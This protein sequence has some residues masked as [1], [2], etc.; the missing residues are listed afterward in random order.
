[1][2]R[3]KKLFDTGPVASAGNGWYVLN[4]QSTLPIAVFG[5]D[6]G[7]AEKL[8]RGLEKGYALQRDAE[9]AIFGM[10]S[11]STTFRCR[12]ID[13]YKREFS[14]PFMAAW[15][16]MREA[17]ADWREL[18]AKG[19]AAKQRRARLSAD[20]HRSLV[21]AWGEAFRHAAAVVSEDRHDR[22]SAIVA[23]LA[24][25]YTAGGHALHDR[26][27]HLD[28]DLLVSVLGWTLERPRG[29]C[30]HV[31]RARPTDSARDQHPVVP[32]HA[33]CVCRVFPKLRS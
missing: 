10:L 29:G 32:L 30:C 6:V 23:L 18:E 11:R 17:S 28:P 25:T 27:H 2:P 1:M 15:Q 7:G 21:E 22:I 3:G 24:L 14:I 5:V 33:G 16:Q 31:C 12:E 19:E 9:E 13:A 26:E 20:M 4:P 8:K